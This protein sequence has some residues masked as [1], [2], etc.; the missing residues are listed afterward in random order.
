MALPSAQMRIQPYRPLLQQMVPTLT[1]VVP[2]TTQYPCS[3]A[4]GA[5]HMVPQTTQHPAL[6]PASSSQASSTRVQSAQYVVAPP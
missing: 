4:F 2:Y 1:A 5:P 6:E 3:P